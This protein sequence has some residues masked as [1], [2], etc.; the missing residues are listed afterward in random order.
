MIALEVV[1]STMAT[2]AAAIVSSTPAAAHTGYSVAGVPP[3]STTA[4]ETMAD[5]RAFLFGYAPGSVTVMAT[6][7]GTYVQADDREGSRRR[8]HDHP[9]HR[10]TPSRYDRRA[11]TRP[12]YAFPRSRVPVRL[13][14][15]RRLRWPLRSS[16]S[17]T[18]RA[19]AAV[20]CSTT[21][22][23]CSNDEPAFVPVRIAGPHPP[24]R[25][26]RHRLDRGDEAPRR[27]PA[28]SG[29]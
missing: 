15:R 19:S 17:P 7:A 21:S 3:V 20:S 14:G 4:T 12:S 11:W 10:I 8:I 6:A 27:D 29:P 24:D 23:H 5:G 1:D 25:Q 26:A 28:D 18:C 9:R 22:A 16:T 13:A 2:V